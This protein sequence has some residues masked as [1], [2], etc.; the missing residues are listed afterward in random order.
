LAAAVVAVVTLIVAVAIITGVAI[1]FL[2][3]AYPEVIAKIIRPIMAREI[4]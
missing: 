3:A 2:A 1:E 4:K